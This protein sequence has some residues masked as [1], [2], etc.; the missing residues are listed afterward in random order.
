MDSRVLSVL[1][2][3]HTVLG[4][5]RRIFPSTM[6]FSNWWEMMLCLDR[7]SCHASF[8]YLCGNAFWGMTCHIHLH[9]ALCVISLISRSNISNRNKEGQFSNNTGGSILWSRVGKNEGLLPKRVE[10][11]KQRWSSWTFCKNWRLYSKSIPEFATLIWRTI[12]N[13]WCS[14]GYS[15]WLFLLGRFRWLPRVSRATTENSVVSPGSSL[16]T[17]WS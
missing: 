2:S 5:H 12:A 1:S 11:M 8:L 9:C 10:R 16:G 7:R 4:L 6:T 17:P 13:S 15:F 3:H 14:N